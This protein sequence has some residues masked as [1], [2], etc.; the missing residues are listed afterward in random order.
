MFLAAALALRLK[1]KTDKESVRYYAKQAGLSPQTII[2]ILNGTTWP[3]L[4]TIARL[5]NAVDGKLWGNEHR[6]YRTRHHFPRVRSW[7]D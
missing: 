3:D 4:R 2:N 7:Y 5:E 6:Q 1:A